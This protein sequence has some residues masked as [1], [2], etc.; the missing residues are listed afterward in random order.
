V[1]A[2]RWMQKSGLAWMW[3]MGTDPKRLLG[4]YAR[5]FIFLRGAALS[6][7]W[8]LRH[9][10]TA[11]AD[12]SKSQAEDTP[13]HYDMLRWQ[14]SIERSRID[15]INTPESLDAP[16]LL[17]CSEVE[18]ID[19][20]GLGVLAG[21]TRKARSSGHPFALLRPSDAVSNALKAVRMDTLLVSVDTT[22][23]FEQ[24]LA[25]SAP[26]SAVLSNGNGF[27]LKPSG[28]LE[29]ATLDD[30]KQKLES[31]MREHPDARRL[32]LDMGEV[33]FLDS[34]GVGVLL[35]ARRSLCQRGGDLI[36]SNLQPEVSEL[37]K[38]LKLDTVLPT[39]EP[40][41]APH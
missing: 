13:T 34:R 36:L 23:A 1:R 25:T 26:P 33:S 4:R 35:S 10:P 21:L 29:G 19:S 2:P 3:R 31:F 8:S 24:M 22:E 16:L 7:L 37:L 32:I 5:D 20:A 39:L 14:G 40:T 17:D 6:Q 9:R 11:P 38:L 28:A 18:F 41:E 12:S 15:Q 30:L 27:K